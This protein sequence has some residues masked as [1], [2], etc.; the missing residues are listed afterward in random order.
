M[1]RFVE[2]VLSRDTLGDF[3][4]LDCRLTGRRE[5]PMLEDRL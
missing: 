4:S 1:L 3:C 5:E 2:K